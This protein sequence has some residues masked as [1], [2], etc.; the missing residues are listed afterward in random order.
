MDIKQSLE[1]VK[2]QITWNRKWSDMPAYL[3]SIRV[4]EKL[5]EYNYSET[6][7]IAWLLHDIIED[8]S[9]RLEKLKELWYSDEI[10][11]L[12]DYST[13]DD[14]ILNT[15]ERW[16]SM[17]ARIIQDNNK[18]AFVIKFCDYLDNLGECHQMPNRD[19]LMKFLYIKAPFFIYFW[20]KLLNNKD[21]YDELIELYRKQITD[22][23]WY[24][25]KE[26]SIQELSND[27]VIW[28]V[29]KILQQSPFTHDEPEI[30]I[31]AGWFASWKTRHIENTYIKSHLYIDPWKIMYVLSQNNSYGIK[32]M[33]LNINKVWNILTHIAI[34]KKF[35]IVVEVQDN[36]PEKIKELM[37]NMIKRWY[38]VTLMDFIVDKETSENY[39]TNRSKFNLTSDFTQQILFP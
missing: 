19:K 15:Y 23:S 17:M 13:H 3:D 30:I 2:S 29:E 38:K 1:L 25:K 10:L 12:V 36:E 8:G 26:I 9:M 21:L 11:S 18:N 22:F 37:D 4:Y 14:K 27:D 31:V 33:V 5:K 35:N 6:I 20:N 24:F 7:Q 28:Y 16:E 32:N 34:E 39:H